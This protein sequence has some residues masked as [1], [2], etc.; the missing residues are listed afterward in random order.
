MSMSQQIRVIRDR[1]GCCDDERMNDRLTTRADSKRPLY[2]TTVGIFDSGA[3]PEQICGQQNLGNWCLAALNVPWMES[4]CA[5]KSSAVLLQRK[6]EHPW[7]TRRLAL[8][9]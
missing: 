1:L 6:S 3:T 4:R 2:T 8:A 5:S 9:G 7:A